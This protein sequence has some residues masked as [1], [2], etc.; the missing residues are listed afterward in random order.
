MDKFALTM[1]A[2][3]FFDRCETISRCSTSWQSSDVVGRALYPGTGAILRVSTYFSTCVIMFCVMNEDNLQEE[4]Q[5]ALRTAIP[6]TKL[7]V[8]Q[9]CQVRYSTS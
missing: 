8:V 6:L 5:D 3:S 2:T 7:H 4:I 9:V 1:V